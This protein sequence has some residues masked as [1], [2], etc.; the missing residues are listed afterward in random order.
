MLRT[1]P[2]EPLRGQSRYFDGIRTLRNLG[3]V[4][5]LLCAALATSGAAAPNVPAHAYPR[6]PA[7]KTPDPIALGI[8]TKDAPDPS[9]I[10]DYTSLVGKAPSIVM[11][12]TE[13]DAPL[14]SGPQQHDIDRLH[15]TPLI[16]WRPVIN[17]HQP[18]QF[19][20]IAAGKYDG[21]LRRQAVLARN[22]HRPILIRFAYEMNLRGSNY[23]SDVPGETPAT[24]IAAWRHVVTVFRQAGATNVRWVWSP[25]TDC[26][27]T[28]PFT[29]YFPGAQ[30]VDWLALDGYNFASAHHAAWVSL[31]YVF[32]SSYKTITA[33]A[34][35]PVMFAEI[36]SAP[37]P[38]NKAH[39][40]RNGFDSTIPT[41]FPRV[42]AVVWFDQDKEADWRVNSSHASL[43]AWRVVARSPLYEGRITSSGLPSA[44]PAAPAR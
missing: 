35:K 37:S 32:A 8:T 3:I 20:D 10:K 18:L 41:D 19:A 15:A 5:G 44:R 9:E 24:F 13:F 16:S 38:G 30:Y 17:G 39:W 6:R 27:G 12:Y 42:R 22:T 21:Y 40:I 28:C 26:A 36:A 31:H 1:V 34:N 11:W 25:N 14:F 29:A 7:H 23:G 33:L 4:T 2:V 43:K